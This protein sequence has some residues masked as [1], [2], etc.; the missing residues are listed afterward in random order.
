MTTYS[1]LSRV[2]S[3]V[4]GYLLSVV[5]FSLQSGLVWRINYMFALGFWPVW[6]REAR[7]SRLQTEEEPQLEKL[8][9]I[10]ACGP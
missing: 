3:V 7:V 10:E 1:S 5:S 4:L 6:G 8:A 9:G 2:V